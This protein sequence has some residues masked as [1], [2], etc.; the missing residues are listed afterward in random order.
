MRLAYRPGEGGVIPA[1]T[2]QYFTYMLDKDESPIAQ[3]E[4]VIGSFR[5]MLKE[6]AVDF[7]AMAYLHDIPHGQAV[8]EYMGM[9]KHSPQ[10]EEW[11]LF[12]EGIIKDCMDDFGM[13]RWWVESCMNFNLDK[14]IRGGYERAWQEI[15]TE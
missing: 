14:E 3:I 11:V 9:I 1:P 12:I 7:V 15:V 4:V 5:G 8:N 2:L 10:Y 6:Y 13:E